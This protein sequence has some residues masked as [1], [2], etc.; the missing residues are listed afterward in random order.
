MSAIKKEN[1]SKHRINWVFEKLKIIIQLLY[2]DK[3]YEGHRFG[4][5]AMS[6]PK[7]YLPFDLITI[8]RKSSWTKH[9]RQPS[10]SHPIYRRFNPEDALEGNLQDI[11]LKVCKMKVASAESKPIPPW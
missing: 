7:L 10:K 8:S 4:Y 1:P 11:N 9:L 3:T 5:N 6:A 2:R